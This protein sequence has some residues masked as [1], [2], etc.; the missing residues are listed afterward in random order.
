MRDA[1][2]RATEHNLPKRCSCSGFFPSH[3]CKLVA[4]A[5]FPAN[6]ELVYWASEANPHTEISKPGR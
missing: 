4:V 3:S 6:S 1:R 2:V 5:S